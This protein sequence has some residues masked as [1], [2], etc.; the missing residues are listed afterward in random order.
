ML[1]KSRTTNQ[2]YAKKKGKRRKLK[3]KVTQKFYVV[4][5]HL[6]ISLCTCLVTDTMNLLKFSRFQKNHLYFHIPGMNIPKS[7]TLLHQTS[8]IQNPYSL[9]LGT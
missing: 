2:E 9:T 8:I 5:L 4:Q 3:R 6:K 1:N 7:H